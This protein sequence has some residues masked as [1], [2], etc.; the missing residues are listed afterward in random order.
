MAVYVDDMR[1]NFG[2]MVMCHMLADS[3]D[4]LHAMAD[5]IGVDRRWWQSPTKTSGSHYDIALS[6]RALA[7]QLGAVQI[8]WKQAG[9]M[10]ARRR[11]TGDLGRPDDAWEWLHAHNAGLR[12]ARQ[13][14]GE[15]CASDPTDGQ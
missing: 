6:K 13:Q 11:V 14:E 1:A 5:R 12:Q 2:R 8:T 10:N 15:R 3:D 9:A 7:V 4:E